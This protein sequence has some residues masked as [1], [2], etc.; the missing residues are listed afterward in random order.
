ME[1][2]NDQHKENTKGRHE[3]PLPKEITQKDRELAKAAHEEAE[4]DI[5]NDAEF[6]ASSPNDDL[7]EGETA[8]LGEDETGLV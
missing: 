7:D 2:R 5:E 4:K 3:H 8:K 1:P 6:S